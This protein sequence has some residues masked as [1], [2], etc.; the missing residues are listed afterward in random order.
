MVEILCITEPDTDESH[1]KVAKTAYQTEE[2]SSGQNQNF[3]CVFLKV[4]KNKW[5]STLHDVPL[6]N[7]R[8][9]V[10]NMVVEVP[11]WTSEEM[12]IS[13]TTPLNPICPSVD[14]DRKQRLVANV[15]PSHG[16][17]WNAGKLPQTWQNPF[18]NDERTNLLGDNGPV[19]VLEI[20]GR[21]LGRGRVVGVKLLG[22]Y[23]VNVGDVTNWKAIAIAAD[24][25]NANE[26]NDVEDV[27]ALFPGLLEYAEWWLRTHRTADGGRENELFGGR[28]RNASTASAVVKVSHKHWGDMQADSTRKFEKLNLENATLNNFWTKSQ[29]ATKHYLKVSTHS[30]LSTTPLKNDRWYYPSANDNNT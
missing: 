17:P 30:P 14:G 16:H 9:P 24:D 11:R 5:V 18:V 2:R 21:V 4:G 10:Y 26:V 6:R 22:A 8:D 1:R 15:F 19:D 3:N 7:K 25:P 29:D 13:K 27:R 12:E 23:A 28:A 20:G